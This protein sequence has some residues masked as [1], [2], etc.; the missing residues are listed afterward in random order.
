M[1]SNEFNEYMNLILID[2][3]RKCEGIQDSIR[4]AMNDVQKKSQILAVN[5]KKKSNEIYY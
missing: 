1:N 2:E 3:V 5:V 4:N